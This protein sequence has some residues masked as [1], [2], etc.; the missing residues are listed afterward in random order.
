MLP[1]ERANQA[2]RLSQIIRLAA[3]ELDAMACGRDG[4]LAT[5]DELHTLAGECLAVE[6]E[7]A[8][9]AGSLPFVGANV[10]LGPERTPEQDRESNRVMGPAYEERAK[11]AA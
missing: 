9:P 2:A 1:T 5:M 10:T 7:R 11:G 4:S 3:D 8:R 6:V